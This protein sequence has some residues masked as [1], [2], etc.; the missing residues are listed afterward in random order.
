MASLHYQNIPVEFRLCIFC[1]DNVCESEVHFLL[2]CN[3]YNDLREELFVYV[4]RINPIFHSLSE[5]DKIGSLMSK[6]IVKS[7]AQFI[8]KAIMKRRQVLYN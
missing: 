8:Q 6:D 4:A 7:T 5:F 2:H 1:N 3:L